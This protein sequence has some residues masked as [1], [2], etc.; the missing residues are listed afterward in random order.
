MKIAIHTAS[1]SFS[2]RWI[3]Y[4]KN[5]GINYKLVNAYDSDIVSQIADC[6]A[7]M[8]HHLHYYYKDVLFARQLLYSLEEAGKK[9]FPDWRTCWHFDDK[10]GQ[11]YLLEAAGLPIVPS[12]VFFSKKEAF[13]WIEKTTFPKV[14]KLRGGASA[15]NVK[16]VHSAKEARH[17]VRKAFGR[18]FSQFDRIGYLKERFNKWRNGRDTILGVIKGLGRLLIPTEY[19]KMHSREKGYV[20]FQDFIPD[21]SYDIRVIVIDGKAF[22]IKRFVR[23]NDFRASGSGNI[24]Y[25]KSELNEDCVRCSFEVEEKLRTQCIAIDFVLKDDKPLIVE[26]SYCFSP[27]PYDKCEGYWTK[28]MQW[29][30]GP[31]NPQAWMIE[32]LIQSNKQ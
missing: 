12:Y 20:Y 11:K 18:G 16:L 23:E 31:F 6:E 22:A 17:Y 10:V 21:N 29:H 28:D 13:A 25:A 7:F 26:L 27:T 14:F 4:C 30:V 1:G 8:W 32:S 3:E 15:A 24:R 19:S 9:V 2:D 5:K